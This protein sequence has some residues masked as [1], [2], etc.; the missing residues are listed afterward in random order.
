VVDYYGR[1][2]QL[3][4]LVNGGRLLGCNPS[5]RRSYRLGRLRRGRWLTFVF[6]V[7]WSPYKRGGFVEVWRNGRKV[8]PLK[9]VPTLY[10]GTFV[11]VKQGFYRAPTGWPSVVYHDGLRRYSRKPR[12]R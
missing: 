7:R 10:A 1:R 8:L 6:H 11:Y 2:P 4:L 12:L 9:H 5:S 3:R